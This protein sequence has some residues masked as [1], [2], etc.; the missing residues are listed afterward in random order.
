MKLIVSRCRWFDVKLEFTNTFLSEIKSLIRCLAD[1][2]S[3]KWSLLAIFIDLHRS[4]V[5]LVQS[6][7]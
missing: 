4:L 3:I 6:S 5:K 7:I 2:D 1:F